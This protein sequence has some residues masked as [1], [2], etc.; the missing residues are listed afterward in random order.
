MYEN[1]NFKRDAFIKVTCRRF[2]DKRS[3]TRTT[4]GG[5]VGRN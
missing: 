2:L 4:A 5:Q 1:K 3:E